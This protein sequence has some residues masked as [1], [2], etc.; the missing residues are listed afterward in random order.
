M[1]TICKRPENVPV[2][3]FEPSIVLSSVSLMDAEFFTTTT[4]YYYIEHLNLF[5]VFSATQ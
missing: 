2:A 3:E 1:Y 4:T 5:M